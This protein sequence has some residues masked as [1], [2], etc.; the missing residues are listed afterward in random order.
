MPIGGTM[1]VMRP[2]LLSLLVAAAACQSYDLLYR[3]PSDQQGTHL[4]FVV[5]TPSKADILFVIDNSISMTEEQQALTESVDVLLA[6]LAPQDTSYRIGMVATDMIG[7]ANSAECYD[8]NG[9]P[10]TGPNN[11]GAKGNCRCAGYL[12]QVSCDATAGCGWTSCSCAG[13][14]SQATCEAAGCVWRAGGMCRTDEETRRPHDGALGRLMAVYDPVEFDVDN[15]ATFAALRADPQW[16]ALLRPA[17]VKI[18]P[19]GTYST[20]ALADPAQ[21][22]GFTGEEGARWVIDRETI[23]LEACQACACTKVELGEVKCDEDLPCMAACVRPIAPTVV[24]AY[25]RANVR[26]LGI[27]GSGHEEGIKA[28]L[29]AGGVDPEETDDAIALAAP[30][31]HTSLTGTGHNTFKTRDAA[32][33]VVQ[34]S[35]LRDEALFAILIV[36]DEQDCSMQRGVFAARCQ[37]EEGCWSTTCD[38]GA[39]GCDGSW[40]PPGNWS[41]NPPGSMCYQSAVQQNNLVTAL[42]MASLIGQKKQSRSRVAV[43][44]IGGVNKTGTIPGLEGRE[45]AEADCAVDVNGLPTNTCS[46]LAGA[47]NNFFC[48]MWCQYTADN[49]GAC[50]PSPVPDYCDAMAGSRYVRFA[51]EFRRRTYESV[52]LA[53]GGQGFGA[54]MADFARIATLACFDLGDV[55]PAG[56]DPSLITVKR[57]SKANAALGLPPALLPPTDSNSLSEGWYYE[58]G[59]NRICLTGLDR[60]IGD[61]Y[62]IFVLHTNQIAQPQ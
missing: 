24:E 15:A 53:Q 59:D 23:K 4:H 56:G 9:I 16:A 60:L 46:C 44:F 19:T 42:R 13:P 7:C 54:A 22:P 49:G 2:T 6:A 27:N 43:G 3:P 21:F 40:V 25:F 38:Y 18:L 32:G 37:L 14:S 8:C 10:L 45:G 29:R 20:P 41:Q 51:N 1:R 34:A 58:A 36:S 52:C 28:A 50:M 57:A 30:N 33:A 47:P 35:W 17:L 5:E 61:V 11:P 31:D 55:R 12:S 26:G 62:D 48:D 39:G